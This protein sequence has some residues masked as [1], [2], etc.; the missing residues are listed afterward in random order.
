VLN[1]LWL[2]DECRRRGLAHV[3]LGYFVRGCAKMSYK[4]G[5]RPCE[6]LGADGAWRPAAAAP[7]LTAGAPAS[8]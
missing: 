7:P 1:V 2:I 6:L 5:F 3:Y 8:G 4:A